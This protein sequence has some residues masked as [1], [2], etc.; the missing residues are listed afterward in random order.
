[1]WVHP[2]P[3]REKE[4]PERAAVKG[5]MT[6]IVGLMNEQVESLTTEQRHREYQIEVLTS[7]LD[8]FAKMDMSIGEVVSTDDG[9]MT[10]ECK[11]EIEGKKNLSVS[12][13][14]ETPKVK[15]DPVAQ[16]MVG[17]WEYLRTKYPEL[18][19]KETGK[20]VT[21]KY[22]A[23]GYDIAHRIAVEWVEKVEKCRQM[24][25]EDGEKKLRELLEKGNGSPATKEA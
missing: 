22:T 16:L 2:I 9:S 13:L 8:E 1:M 15:D 19:G 23:D 18:N 5:L 14:L 6:T 12:T 3:K 21:K 24:Y 10:I 4:M 20:K 17:A 7:N 11:K 25:Q